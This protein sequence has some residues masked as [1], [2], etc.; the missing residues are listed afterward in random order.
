MKKQ[1]YCITVNN[2]NIVD[3]YYYYHYKDILKT[4]VK[5]LQLGYIVK[6]KKYN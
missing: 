2:N 6:V 4:V 5:Y 1:I 3:H